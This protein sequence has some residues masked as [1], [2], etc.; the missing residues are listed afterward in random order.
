M[1][2][3]MWRKSQAHEQL[4][5]FKKYITDLLLAKRKLQPETSRVVQKRL[6]RDYLIVKQC[7]TQSTFE[8]RKSAIAMRIK[9]NTVYKAYLAAKCVCV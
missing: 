3:M 7:S 8:T 5:G 6:H 9:R 1:N 2:W 4:E